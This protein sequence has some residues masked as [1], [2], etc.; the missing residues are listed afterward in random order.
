MNRL[1]TTIRYIPVL[2]VLLLS[3]RLAHATTGTEAFEQGDFSA[4][5]TLLENEIAANDDPRKRLLLARIEMQR[6]EFESAYKL[7]DSVV[8]ELPDDAD[9]HYWLGASAGSLA[10]NVS[11]FRAAR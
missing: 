2:L 7:M 9:A 6:N 10:G 8:D 5:E 3:A 11:L 4:A 1:K